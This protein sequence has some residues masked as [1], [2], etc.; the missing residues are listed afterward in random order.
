M[1]NEISVWISIQNQELD[2]NSDLIVTGR[3]L[4]AYDSSL[5]HRHI[6]GS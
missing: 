4:E 5:A 1:K 2:R 6:F 3:P